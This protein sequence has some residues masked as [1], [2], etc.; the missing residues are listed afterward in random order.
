MSQISVAIFEWNHADVE[1]LKKSKSVRV[2][3]AKMKNP[4]IE[5]A[6]KAISKQELAGHCRQKTRSVTNTTSMLENFFPFY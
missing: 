6:M 2:A 4:S 3:D 1:F 5:T